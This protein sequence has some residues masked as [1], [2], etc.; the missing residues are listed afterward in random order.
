MRSSAFI[1]AGAPAAA[2]S[3][4]LRPRCA[5]GLAPLSLERVDVLAQ[6]LDLLQDLLELVLGA[7]ELARPGA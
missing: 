6:A 3:R 1:D 4:R 7:A 2:R 5:A